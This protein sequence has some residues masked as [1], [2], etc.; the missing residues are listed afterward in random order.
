MIKDD[1]IRRFWE[2]VDKTADC[3][4][5]K[6][7][8]DRKGYGKFHCPGWHDKSNTMVAAHRFS[9]VLANGEIPY[10][11]SHHGI[12]VLHKCDNPK[13]VRPDHLFLGTNEDNVKD[14]DNKK[15]RVTVSYRGSK[16]S[17]SKLNEK[18]VFEIY[19]LHKVELVTQKRISEIYKVSIS[20]INHIFKGRLWSHLKLGEVK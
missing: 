10:H 4:L 8:T 17:N 20:T 9:W 7:G 2:K 15:R 18:D 16:H 12:C 11:D 3:W 13:C 19:R 6:A 5:W 1:R 14:M